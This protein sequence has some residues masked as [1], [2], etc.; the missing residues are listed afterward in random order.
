ML[1]NISA[2]VVSEIV[3]LLV[4]LLG[5]MVYSSLYP[6]PE[7]LNSNDNDAVSMFLDG[8]PDKAF[9]IKILINA[10]AAFFVSLLATIIGS[11][12]KISGTIGLLLFLALVFFRES[13][14]DFSDVFMAAN[15]G[16][17]LFTGILGILLGL[18][19]LKFEI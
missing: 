18:K 3:G 13:K 1:K 2:V 5:M 10:I 11:S 12:K 7:G 8:L 16:I 19:R 4:L 9:R 17:V 15:A 14:Y 6:F